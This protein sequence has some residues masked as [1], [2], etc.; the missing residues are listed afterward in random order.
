MGGPIDP[1][2][3]VTH[4]GKKVYF[5]CKDCIPKFE[6]EPAKYMTKLK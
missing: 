5:C 4:E 1:N 2:V 6:K 3:F